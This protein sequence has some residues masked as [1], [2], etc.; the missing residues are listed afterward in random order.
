MLRMYCLVSTEQPRKALTRFPTNPPDTRVIQTLDIKTGRHN[1]S[2]DTR[3]DDSVLDLSKSEIVGNVEVKETPGKGKCGT[4]LYLTEGG[5]VKVNS[6]AVKPKKA[7]TVT[8][9]VLLRRADRVN[10]LYHSSNDA[11]GRQTL[12]MIPSDNES[13]NAEVRWMIRNHGRYTLFDLVTPPLVPAGEFL[14]HVLIR[15]IPQLLL[16]WTII[17]LSPSLSLM[18]LL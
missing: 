1:N 6:V 7:I 17:P 15:L 11:G 4:V 3:F 14:V 2:D 8:A 18:P 12:S 9:W 16:I 10:M 13:P 5:Y